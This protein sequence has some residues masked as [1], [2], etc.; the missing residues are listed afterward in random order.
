LQQGITVTGSFDV[1]KVDKLALNIELKKYKTDGGMVNFSALRDIPLSNRV[2]AVAKQDLGQ[3]VKIIAV[4][5]TYTFES[6]NLTRPMNAFQILDLAEVLVEESES[7]NIS[8]QDI[9][10][11]LQRLARGYYPGLYEGMDMVK[12]MERFNHYRDERFQAFKQ[13]RDE[14]DQYY[15]DLGDNNHHER[16]NPKDTTA[17]G[18]MMEQY[19]TKAQTQRDERRERKNYDN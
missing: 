2:Y 14:K 10:L 5:L 1:T 3:A 11:F 6:L 8:F 9:L 17:F 7:D 12:F 19:K 18:Q 16:Y 4:A 15:K 13:L